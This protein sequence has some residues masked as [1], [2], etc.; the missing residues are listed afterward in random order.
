MVPNL[1]SLSH[2]YLNLFVPVK[3]GYLASLYHCP[4]SEFGAK[5]LTETEIVLKH[6]V[7]PVIY[8]VN[9]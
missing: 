9:S 3:R 4:L 5:E 1:S 2:Y 7:E 6:H 8:V